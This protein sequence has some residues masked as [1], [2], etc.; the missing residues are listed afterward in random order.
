MI[1]ET[2]CIVNSLVSILLLAI[3]I[4]DLN[5][6]SDFNFLQKLY[7]TY[8]VIGFEDTQFISQET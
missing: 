2:L 8:E 4:I 6:W 3:P 1:S 7:R 5:H